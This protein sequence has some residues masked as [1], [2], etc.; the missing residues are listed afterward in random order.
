MTLSL[1]GLAGFDVQYWDGSA[2][3]TVSGGSVSGNNKVWKK[4]SFPAITTSRIRVLTNASS[5]G[6][7]R[8]TE[9]EAW[10]PSTANLHW[11]V[12]DQLGTP[13]M[14]FDQSGTLTVT[15]SNGNYVSGMT[16]HDYLPFWEE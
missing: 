8:I 16:R 13:R 4:I 15:D 1:Y 3:V 5:D 6:W 10:T 2:W 11:L 9:V 7:S 12:T 14:I